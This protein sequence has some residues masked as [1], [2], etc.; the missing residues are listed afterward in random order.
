MT[1]FI[2]GSEPEPTA[3]GHPHPQGGRLRSREEQP[4]P[5][6]AS[7]TKGVALLARPMDLASFAFFEDCILRTV[8]PEGAKVGTA[9]QLGVE[10]LLFCLLCG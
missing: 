4:L 7:V 8:S 10:T 6:R 5:A 2:E 1:P 9:G 3:P